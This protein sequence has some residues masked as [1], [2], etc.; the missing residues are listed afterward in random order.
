MLRPAAPPR[1]LTAL[2]ALRDFGP[3]GGMLTAA[4][5]QHGDR[6]ALIDDRGRT[7]FAELQAQSDA[8]AHGLRARGLGDG[9]VVAIL[10][11]N[12]MER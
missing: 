1:A 11:R 8:A 5:L 10:C 2:R 4:A 9:A 7:P 3:L 6:D 12:H